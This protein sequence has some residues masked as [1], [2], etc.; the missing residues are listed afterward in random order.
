MK[1]AIIRLV[2]V[3]PLIIRAFGQTAAI[4]GEISGT[5]LDP[6]GTPI[7]NAKVGATN[8]RTGYQQTATTTSVG[9]YRLPVLPLGEYSL[10]VQADGFALYKQSGITLSA[11]STATVDVKLQVQGVTTE[12]VVSSAAPILDSA[13][14][15]QG[16]TLSSNAVLKSSARFAQSFQLHPSAAKREWP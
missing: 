9:L 13:R 12:V 16:S 10:T 5:V 1:L 2:I 11:G 7:V 6:S 4:N 15:D 14:T 8:A 3:L